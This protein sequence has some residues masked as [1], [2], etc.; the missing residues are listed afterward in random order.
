MITNWSLFS[1]LTIR[2]SFTH[3]SF[4]T[5]ISLWTCYFFSWM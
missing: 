2:P 1:F 4:F 5:T 3:V